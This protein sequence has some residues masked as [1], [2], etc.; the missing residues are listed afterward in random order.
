[1]APV[2]L[3]QRCKTFENTFSDVVGSELIFLH[4]LQSA[5][6][7]EKDKQSL[8][9]VTASAGTDYEGCPGNTLKGQM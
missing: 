8:I 7:Q 4:V 1:M 9:P 6:S 2:C 5:S 3:A